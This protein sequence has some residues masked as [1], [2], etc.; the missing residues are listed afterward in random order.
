MIRRPI[1]AGALAVASAMTAGLFAAVPAQA[2][3][4]A[5]GKIVA[6]GGLTVRH[7][8]TT[9]STAKGRLANGATVS[10]VCKVRGSSVDGNTLW[11]L[12]P[13]TLNEWVSARYV[14]NV[15]AAPSWCGTDERFVGRTTTGV[16]K[17]V[18]PTTAAAASGGLARGVRVDIICKLAGQTVDGNNRW[19]Y[20]TD[21]R[22]VAA[23]YVSNVGRVPGWCSS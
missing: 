22:W 4:V 13:P 17:R 10:I 5:D 19:Y 7:L 21:G 2:D 11:Y 14:R 23:R 20:L 12:L 16:T 6:A 18:A 15:G 9:A 3:V 8:P 1:R